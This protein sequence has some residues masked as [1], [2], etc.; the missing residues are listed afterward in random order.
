MGAWLL[1]RHVGPALRFGYA[2][3]L[4]DWRRI[5]PALI[6]LPGESPIADPGG[7][8]LLTA[9]VEESRRRDSMTSA[10]GEAPAA[11]PREYYTIEDIM[12][13]E[14]MQALF[15]S[16]ARSLMSG[17]DVLFRKCPSRP[18]HPHSDPKLP[19][20]SQTWMS[21]LSRWQSL[22]SDRIGA[23]GRNALA[24]VQ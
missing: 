3:T 10:L 8:R 17:D 11:I 5:H 6:P 21:N 13:R 7:T 9:A 1:T 22:L 14:G 2:T 18:I 12:K 19:A 4:S 15:L 20:S 24:H 23:T 16:Y